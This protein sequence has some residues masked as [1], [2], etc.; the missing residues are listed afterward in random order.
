[1]FLVSRLSRGPSAIELVAS[2]LLFDHLI[3]RLVHVK[4]H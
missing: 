4:P 3:R 2:M 1:M